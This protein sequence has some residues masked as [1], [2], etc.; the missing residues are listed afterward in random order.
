MESIVNVIEARHLSKSPKQWLYRGD[1]NGVI[2]RRQKSM[3]KSCVK[4]RSVITVLFSAV[5]NR[6]QRAGSKIE[7]N[8]RNKKILINVLKIIGIIVL[9]FVIGYLIWTYGQVR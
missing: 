9:A 8:M 1:N 4:N 6:G 5:K 3:S 2:Q 7:V